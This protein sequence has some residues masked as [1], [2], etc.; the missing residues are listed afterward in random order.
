LLINRRVPVNSTLETFLWGLAALLAV[1]FLAEAY[2]VV[3]TTDDIKQSIS[4]M[5]TSLK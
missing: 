4:E 2:V 5:E 1:A 3:K